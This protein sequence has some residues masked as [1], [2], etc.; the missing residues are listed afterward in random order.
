MD[1]YSALL[2][3]PPHESLKIWK[4]VKRHSRSITD[5]FQPPAI[6]HLSNYP[7]VKKFSIGSRKPIV[8]KSKWQLR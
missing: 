2:R 8:T 3:Q 1:Y 7:N 5:S 4:V 6:V